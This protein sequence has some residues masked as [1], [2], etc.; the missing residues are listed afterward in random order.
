M[1]AKYLLLVLAIMFLYIGKAYANECPC[2]TAESSGSKVWDEVY[3]Y[4]SDAYE[5]KTLTIRILYSYGVWNLA[6]V[7]SKDFEPFIV[8]LKR[9]QVSFDVMAE[10]GGMV[11]E[12]DTAEV[13]SSFF[14]EKA[15]DTPAC[16]L[17]SYTP[18][19]PPFSKLE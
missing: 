9:S 11:E 4:I 3:K 6:E 2:V 1:R 13:V 8:L 16:L 7:E 10:W 19:G 5:T 18:K 17:K 14:T 15:P 12:G